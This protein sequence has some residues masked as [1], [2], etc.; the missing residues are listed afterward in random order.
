MLP[1]APRGMSLSL[2]FFVS[3]LLFV[4]A[5]ILSVNFPLLS[6][7]SLGYCFMFLAI[8]MS[9][10]ICLPLAEPIRGTAP[11]A[12]VTRCVKTHVMTLLAKP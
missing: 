3:L 7:F 11:T 4:F 2:F 8:Q 12:H 5:I 9:L 10:L 1:H 6:S